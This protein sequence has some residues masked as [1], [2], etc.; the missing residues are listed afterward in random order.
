M[1]LLIYNLLILLV[2][3]LGESLLADQIGWRSSSQMNRLTKQ[4]LRPPQIIDLEIQL[5]N[6]LH[7][8]PS[9]SPPLSFIM[10]KLD[11]SHWSPYSSKAILLKD[12]LSRTIPMSNYMIF[13]TIGATHKTPQLVVIECR[14]YVIANSNSDLRIQEVVSTIKLSKVEKIT[15]VIELDTSVP[16]M[17]KYPTTHIR[18]SSFLSVMLLTNLSGHSLSILMLRSTI[19]S[20]VWEFLNFLH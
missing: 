11:H 10:N 2:P 12:L 13:Q 19:H 17:F 14:Y 16:N 18:Q 15:I 6:I 8:M 7:L 1:I 4:L 5:S 3:R 20:N 9:R